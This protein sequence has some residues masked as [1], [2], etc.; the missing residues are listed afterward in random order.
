MMPVFLQRVSAVLFT[1]AAS[2]W[3]PY[4]LTESVLCPDGT[5]HDWMVSAGGELHLDAAY[6]YDV[7]YKFRFGIATPLAGRDYF[8]GGNAVVYFALGLAF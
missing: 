5:P 7:P 4:G 1:D 8:G 3:C 6:Q 2:A